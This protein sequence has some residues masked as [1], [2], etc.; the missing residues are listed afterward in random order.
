MK[1]I[2]IKIMAESYRG[3]EF[4]RLERKKKMAKVH[5]SAHLGS[6]RRRRFRRVTVAVLD[7]KS[8]VEDDLEG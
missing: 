7:V 6:V 3:V 1:Q 4:G 2:D 8:L 5:F